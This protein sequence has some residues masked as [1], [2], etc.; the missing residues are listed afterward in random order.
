MTQHCDVAILGAGPY[1]LSVAAHLKTI[2]GLDV[3]TFGDAMSF[4]S[5]QM[6]VGMLLRSAYSASHLS[7][8]S[9]ALSLKG[10]EAARGAAIGKPVSL[11]DFVQYGLWFQQQAVPDLDSRKI[12]CIDRGGDGFKLLL[13]DETELQ[14]DRVVVAGGIGPFAQVPQQ[15]RGL[16]Q[17]LAS[18]SSSLKTPQSFAGK[19]V[20]VVGSGQSALESAVLLQEAGADVEVLMR[21][22]KVRFI[23]W[24]HRVHK[25]GPVARIFY[26]PTDVGPAGISRLVAAPQLYRMLL[27]RPVQDTLRD[28]C[29]RPAGAFWLRPRL[30]AVR[31]TTG[32]VVASAA[33]AGDRVRLKLGDGSERTCD[34]VLLGTGYRVDVSHYSFLSRSMEPKIR[35]VNGFPVLDFH[36]E[37]SIPKLHFVGAPSAWSFGPLMFFVAGADFTARTLASEIQGA[38]GN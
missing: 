32:C 2:P 18:H 20:V 28:F 4:W 9:T 8:P 30:Q 10:Y 16:P 7:A 27:P 36:F 14:A 31:V 34:H 21:R 23:G 3:Q 19:T 26:A 22:S 1:G 13:E 6:P 17:G 38:D 11:E 12:V 24:S 25:L 29:R 5:G 35:K 15:F 33:A 37:S